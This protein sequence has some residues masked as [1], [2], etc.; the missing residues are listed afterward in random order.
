MKDTQKRK[1]IENKESTN[2]TKKAFLKKL[3]KLKRGSLFHKS[4]LKIAVSFK[5]KFMLLDMLNNTEGE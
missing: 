5:L 3:A 2:R 4:A 1:T